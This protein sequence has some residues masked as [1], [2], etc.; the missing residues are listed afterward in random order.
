M[1]RNFKPMT[2][3]KDMKAHAHSR[4]KEKKN[5]EMKETKRLALSKAIGKNGKSYFRLS[6]CFDGEIQKI[7]TRVAHQTQE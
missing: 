5:C 6:Q 4:F 3:A 2:V 7:M 1:G